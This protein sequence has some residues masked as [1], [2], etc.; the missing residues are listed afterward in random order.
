MSFLRSA[1]AFIR[2]NGL[3]AGWRRACSPFPPTCGEGMKLYPG[4]ASRRQQTPQSAARCVEWFGAALDLRREHGAFPKRQNGARE[5]GYGHVGPYATV[6]LPIRQAPGK[7]IRPLPPQARQIFA[8]GVELREFGR[9]IAD[10]A[11]I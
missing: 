2:T 5:F 10:Q 1:S 9:E 6:A 4:Y 8:K 3:P 11:A 7:C